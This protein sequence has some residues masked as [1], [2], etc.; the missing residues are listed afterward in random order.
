MEDL[1]RRASCRHQSIR[2]LQMTTH[3]CGPITSQIP[4][5]KASMDRM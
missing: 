5:T 1:L 3:L 4:A 2:R